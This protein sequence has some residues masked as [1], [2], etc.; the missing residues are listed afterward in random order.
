MLLS[1]EG[2]TQDD[3]D[4]GYHNLM[5]AYKKLEEHKADKPTDK[6]TENPMDKPTD[7][8]TENPEH[9]DPDDSANENYLPLTGMSS[10]F[11]SVFLVGLGM[12]LIMVNRRRR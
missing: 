9:T 3:V 8:G 1:Q 5:T 10:K 6:P 7:I 2:I 11:E 12:A 4:E